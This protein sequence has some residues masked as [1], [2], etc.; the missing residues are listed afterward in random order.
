MHPV[1]LTDINIAV[2]N[3]TNWDEPIQEVDEEIETNTERANSWGAALTEDSTQNK[4]A[5]NIGQTCNKIFV[6]THH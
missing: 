2:G 3:N 6:K 1:T 5:R 4:N